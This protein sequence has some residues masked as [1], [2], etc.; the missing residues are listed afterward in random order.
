MIM[1]LVTCSYK[2]LR[3]HNENRSKNSNYPTK[4]QAFNNFE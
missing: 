1:A 3:V 2:I 4:L